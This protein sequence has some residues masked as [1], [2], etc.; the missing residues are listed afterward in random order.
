MHRRDFLKKT[1]GGA[2]TLAAVKM[3]GP[4]FAQ[5]ASDWRASERPAR[6]GNPVFQNRAA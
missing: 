6:P 2:V 3:S 4:A 1:L 5:K